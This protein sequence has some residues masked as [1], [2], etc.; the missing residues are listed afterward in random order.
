MAGHRVGRHDAGDVGWIDSHVDRLLKAAL[1]P[2]PVNG[3]RPWI[4][5]GLAL[6]T[7][8]FLIAQKDPL[9]PGRGLCIVILHCSTAPLPLKVDSG[10]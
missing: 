2:F 5:E 9:F 1:K 4:W 7:V 10:R 8:S 3:S 6:A